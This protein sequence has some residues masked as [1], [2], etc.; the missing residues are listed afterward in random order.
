MSY[1]YWICM[2]I[3]NQAAGQFGRHKN[4]GRFWVQ[5]GSTGFTL[6]EKELSS[7]HHRPPIQPRGPNKRQV[8]HG[9]WNPL[10]VRRAQGFSWSTNW[11]KRNSGSRVRLG[12]GSRKGNMLRQLK[13]IICWHLSRR[14][15]WLRSWCLHLINFVNSCQPIF[16]KRNKIEHVRQYLGMLL[17]KHYISWVDPNLHLHLLA[18]Q[19]PRQDW[20][21]T[22]PKTAEERNF[23]SITVHIKK[24]ELRRMRSRILSWF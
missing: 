12:K 3:P 23:D 6:Q 22:Q 5:D 19:H 13:S 1:A 2:S 17:R 4:S 9:L 20:N 18:W 11:H 15:L 14:K 16:V 8:R 21:P 7:G 24:E 10:A